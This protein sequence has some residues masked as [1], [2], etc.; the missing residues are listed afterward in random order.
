[1]CCGGKRQI[2]GG[3]SAPRRIP[4][5]P[6]TKLAPAKAVVF[7]Y[8]GRTSLTA[9]GPVTGKK[10]FFDRAGARVEVDQRDRYSMASIAQLKLVT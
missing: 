6:A 10:Y 3:G 8:L 2:V 7:E 4:T 9:V 5:S 1:M